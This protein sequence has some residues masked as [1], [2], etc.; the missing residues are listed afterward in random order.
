MRTRPVQL[1]S[2]G[3]HASHRRDVTVRTHITYTLTHV[4]THGKTRRIIIIARRSRESAN[5]PAI[6]KESLAEISNVATYY[7]YILTD[8]ILFFSP[9]CIY[10][11]VCVRA[12]RYMGHHRYANGLVQNYAQERRIV[13]Y[14]T[15]RRI[16][17][18]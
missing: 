8:A 4:H 14:T 15:R 18:R 7:T 1:S 13:A 2:K 9:K 3:E 16:R 11:F 17:D 10:R 5:L 6:E 12:V